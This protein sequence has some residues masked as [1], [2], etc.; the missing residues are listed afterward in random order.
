MCVAVVMMDVDR[1]SRDDLQLMETGNPDGGGIG[2]YEGSRCHWVK[3]LTADEIDLWLD[4]IPRPAMVH[5]RFATVGASIPELCHP[6]PVTKR[7]RL[8]LSGD[9][10]SI[11]IHNGHWS[12]W[13]RIAAR[14]TLPRGP[15]SDT[16]LAAYLARR[17]R[18]WLSIADG[19]FA[20]MEPDG[21]VVL[22]GQWEKVDGVY[23]SNTYWQCCYSSGRS[24]ATGYKSSIGESTSTAKT[25]W[26]EDTEY[27]SW[28]N[29]IF[30]E[31]VA[32]KDPA[33]KKMLGEELA[34]GFR[35]V[36]E[37]ETTY[38]EEDGEYDLV[39]DEPEEPVFG[40]GPFDYSDNSQIIQRF[41]ESQDRGRGI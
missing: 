10:A 6:F 38:Q 30:E 29:E 14:R 34:A 3:G 7:V 41:L 1:P 9:A 16:R 23:Y 24:W 39:Q 21:N 5:F 35:D 2:W 18:K 26:D 11:L 17:D 13:D 12:D 28:L 8:D 31:W 27:Q 37:D 4:E 20:L 32:E 33:R 36:P 40:G 22:Y 15:W 25:V 19:K